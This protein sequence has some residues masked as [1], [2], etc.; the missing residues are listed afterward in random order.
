MDKALSDTRRLQGKLVYFD[1]RGGMHWDDRADR[2]RGII[3]GASGAKVDLVR[4]G[5]DD[6]VVTTQDVAMDW[7]RQVRIRKPVG[8][9]PALLAGIE[10]NLD[11][12]THNIAEC[13]PVNLLRGLESRKTAVLLCTGPSLNL[14]KEWLPRIDRSKA[15]VVAMNSAGQCVGNEHVDYLFGLDYRMLPEWGEA[16]NHITGVFN[17]MCPPALVQHD[18]QQKFVYGFSG[19]G[20]ISD[21]VRAFYRS[22]LPDLMEFDQAVNVLSTAMHFVY[23]LGAQNIIILGMDVARS[24]DTREL[25]WKSNVNRLTMKF[26]EQTFEYAGKT[27]R[28][29]VNYVRAARTAYGNALFLSAAGV[30]VYNCSGAGPLYEDDRGM[31]PWLLRRDLKSPIQAA[32][33]D[34]VIDNLQIRRG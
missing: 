14:A 20:W 7:T 11:N 33:F 21:R 6:I 22:E 18:Y 5:A 30:S 15:F 8:D 3:C 2:A 29:P 10:A 4:G 16:S 32:E 12:V 9:D 1:A 26:S 28:A 23:W 31:F 34:T 17:V 13:L 25:W 24:V 27:W 19:M